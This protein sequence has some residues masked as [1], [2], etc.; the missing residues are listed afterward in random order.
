MIWAADRR[1]PSSEYL[2]KLDQPAI[3]SPTTVSPPTAKK[4]SRPMFKSW[5]NSPGANGMTS[6]PITVAMKT[7]TGASV[8]TRRSAPVGVKSSF[9]STLSPWTTERSEP[10]RTRPGPGRSGG[11]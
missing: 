11:S 5:P 2:L 1:P 10:A 9:A 4:Y 6:S 7:T 8:K 3:S